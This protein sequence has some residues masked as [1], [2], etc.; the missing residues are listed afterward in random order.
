MLLETRLF[1]VAERG[2]GEGRSPLGFLTQKRAVLTF[3]KFAMAYRKMYTCMYSVQAYDLC[4]G[5][6]SNP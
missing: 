4:I 3:G 6:Y 2:R 1:S 5:G